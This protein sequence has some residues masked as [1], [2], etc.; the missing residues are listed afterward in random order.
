MNV[1]PNASAQLR[2]LLAFAIAPC[3]LTRVFAQQRELSVPAPATPL[4]TCDPYFSVWA[5]GKKLTDTT[6]THW[7]GK[8]HRLTGI[9]AIDGASYRFLGSE[10]RKLRA[11]DQIH[12]NITPTQTIYRFSGAGVDLTVKFTTPLLPRDID[13][14]SRPVTYVTFTATATDTKVHDVKLFFQASGELTVNTA[15]QRAE[16]DVLHLNGISAVK[17]GSV[18]Q[19]ILESK[20]DDLRID[21]GFLY[22]AAPKEQSNSFSIGNPEVQR[23]SFIA[24]QPLPEKSTAKSAPADNLAGAVSISIPKLGPTPQSRWLAIAYDDLYSIEYMGS[25]LRPY[26]RRNGSDAAALLVDAARDREKISNACDDFDRELTQ[27]LITAGGDEYAAVATL[28]YRQCFAAGK[29]VADA[30]GQPIHFC[31]ENHSNGCVGTS[32][33]F[34]P[35]SPQFLL[36]GPSLA[37]S[38]VVPFME[39]AK[40]DRWKFPF[41]PHDLGTYPQANGQVYGGGERTEENQMPVEESGNLLILMA[42][43]A[44]LDG[45]ADFAGRYWPRLEQ[46]ANYLKKEG[47]DPAN[48]L[49]T[50]DFAGH[51]AHNVN[52]SAKAICGLGAFAQLCELRGD[53]AQAAEFRKVAEEFAA[54]WVKE[55]DDGDHFRLAFDKPG[56]WSQKYNLVWDSVLGLHLFPADVSQKEMAYYRR[57]QNRFGLPLDNRKDYTKLDWTLWT[58]T[59]TGDQ[60]DFATL[61]HPVY[62]FLGETPDRSPMTDW[63]DTK[64]AK[65][66]GFTA[67]PVVGGVFMQMLQKSELWQK[68]ASRDRT[69]AGDY[70]P[71]PR[72]TKVAIQVEAA[73]TSPITWRFT[74][75]R[76]AGAWY[77]RGFNDSGWQQGRAGFGTEETPG[78]RIGTT[79]NTS[80][81]WLRRAFDLP[82]VA[83]NS[84]RLHVHHDEDA[85]IYING[86]LARRVAGFTTSYEQVRIDPAALKTLSP[87]G[88][89]LAVHCHQTG[90]GQYIDVGIARVESSPK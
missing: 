19:P 69:K 27:D 50:D 90:G 6:T 9:L 74:N 37:K 66:V 1:K 23:D 81:I 31:K 72:P 83:E 45:N 68:W 34:Y 55:A 59:L 47:F 28:A 88:N 30:N 71:L 75:K 82:Q 5:T 48:Q 24:G 4:I 32:D 7:T 20:G 2:Y 14:L 80:D 87:K 36:F 58:A 63:Y 42:A 15:D 33:V 85:E 86:V 54:R 70:A 61:V 46:W 40:S 51:L 41:A 22:L 60:K 26:W 53:K 10:P 39:Y 73:D 18:D 21:W 8:P 13:T 16:G 89:I 25:Q 44:K 49:C 76:P 78:A 64:T 65:K 17:L 38:F 52:L 62:A 11:L 79:W 77:A 3:V 12:S 56:T 67:R 84:L 29:F 43:I 57:V 35:M